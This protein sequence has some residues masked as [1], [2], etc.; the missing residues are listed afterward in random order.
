MAN[1]AMADL[2]VPY[3]LKA[4]NLGANHAALSVIRVI[5][6]EVASDP[7]GICIR[8]HAEFNGQG[9]IDIGSGRLQIAA[10][11]SEAAPPH[12]PQ[13][14]SPIFDLSETSLD[15]ELFV[16]RD[17]SLIVGQGESTISGAGFQ[18]TRD[19]LDVWDALPVDAPP[20]DFPSS[21]FTLDLILNL[22]SVRPP[23]LHPAKMTD[24]GLL[25]PDPAFKEVSLKLPRLRFR[26]SHGNQLNS[27]LGFELVSAGATGLDDPGDI[28]E[29]ELIAMEPPYAFVG[30]PT[31]RVVGFGFRKAVLDLSNDS[32]PPEVVAKFGFGDDWGGL[33]LPEARIFIAPNGAQD[34]AI[35]AGVRDLLIGFGGSA[36]ISGDFELAVIDQGHGALVLSARFFDADNKAYGIERLSDTTGRITVPAQ[37]RMVI[38]VQGG[39]PPYTTS[40]TI[41]AGAAQSG[42]V[43]NVD[44]S[45]TP[46]ATLVIG[47]RDTS[48]GTPKTATLTIQAQLGAPS[49]TLPA[50]GGGPAPA[51][52]ATADTAATDPMIVIAYQNDTSV[53][54]TTDPRNPA[55]MWSVITPPGGA[56]T[57]PTATFTV[58]V[59]PG[60]SR[61]VRARLPATT[62][63]SELTFYFYFDEPARVAN[64]QQETTILGNYAAGSDNIWSTRAASPTRADG[65][66]PGGQNAFDA[67]QQI[68]ETLV[69]AG[70]TIKVWG[71]ASF[72]GE[73][74]KLDYNYQL[75]RRRAIAVR[76][77]L[78]SRHAA[79]V[80]DFT[81]DPE[82]AN[83]TGYGGGSARFANLAAWRA[84]WQTHG[85]PNRRDWWRASVELPPGLGQP[86]K[87]G[88]RTLTRPA[89]QTPPPQIPV[90]DPPAPSEPA[91]PSW[92]R[93]AKLKVRIVRDVLVAVEVDMEVDF[94]TAAE[95]R[96]N[97]SGQVPGG[98]TPTQGRTMR[99]GAPLAPGNPADGITQLR[100][101]A[102][103]DQATGLVTAMIQIGADPADTDGLFAFGWL[104][105]ET[106]PANKDIWLT[107]AGS[108]ISF[109]PMLVD[110]STGNRGGATDAALTVAALAIPG[111]VAL[112]PWFRV[113]RVIV[114]G[115]EYLQRDHASGVFEAYL[116]FDV[117]ADGGAVV[118]IGGVNLNP[119]ARYFP[120]AVRYKAIGLRFGNGDDPA[121]PH[122]TLKP[123]FDASKGF[124]IDVARGGS[125]KIA[126]PF[127]KVLK[128]LAARLS[129]TNPLT[130]EVDIGCGIDLGVVTIERARLRVYLEE[131]IRPPELTAFAASIDVPGAIAGRGYMEMGPGD[132]PGTS[133]IAG[134]IDVTIRPISLRVAAAFEMQDVIDPNDASHR[135]TAIY[136]GL[137]LVLPVG[138]PLGTSGLGIFGFRGI[139]GMHYIRNPQRGANG[140]APALGWLEQ[141][142]GQPHLLQ[143]PVHHA[144]LWKPKIDN[145]AFGVGILLGTMEGGFIVNLDGTLLLELPGPRVAI[146]MNARIISPPPAL[147]GMGS[148]GGI[149]AIIEITPD[150]FLIGVIIDYDISGLIKIHIPV[151]AFFSFTDSSDWHFYLGQRTNPVAVSVLDIVKAT[152]YLM[153]KGNGLDALPA[154]GLPAITGFAI[155][156]GA[157]ASFTWGDTSVGL[158][159]RIAGGFDAVIGFDPFLL[160]GRFEL[161][162]ELRLFIV[163]IGAS[164]ELDIQVI[165]QTGGFKTHIH[166]EACG[167]I[168]FFFFSIEGCVSIT[169]G[170][171]NNKPDLPDLLQKLSVKSR[172][173]A[174]LVGTGVDRPIDTSLGEGVAQ[175]TAPADNDPRL[176]VVPIDSVLVLG[177]ALPPRAPGLQ[178]KGADITNSTGQAPGSFVQRGSEM[179]AYTLSAVDLVRHDGGPALLGGNAPATWW[180]PNDASGDNVNAQLALL[181]WEPD[182]ATKAI[183]KTEQRKE[184]IKQRWSRVCQDSAPPARVLWTFLD[185]RLG[186]SPHGWDLEG[187]PWPDPP[188]TR[189]KQPPATA[190][191]VTE[192]W[193]TGNAQ[194]DAKRG[195][196]PA[197]VV[198]GRIKCTD[199]VP[200]PRIAVGD[201]T[202][203]LGNVAGSPALARTMTPAAATPDAPQLARIAHLAA[204]APNARLIEKAARAEALPD[205]PVDP[206]TV[207]RKISLGGP[208]SRQEIG[209]AF[210]G[211]AAAA[212]AAAA[213]M[214]C[215]TRVLEAPIFDDGRLIVFGNPKDAEAVRAALKEAG[216]E[217]GPLNDV[218]VLHTGAFIDCNVLLFVR[219]TFFEGNRLVLRTLDATGHELSRVAVTVADRLASKPL[220]PRW[221][222]PAGPWARDVRDVLGWKQDARANGFEPAWVTAKGG[223][224]ADRIEI[225]VVDT[226]TNDAERAKIGVGM[227]VIPPYFLGAF[228]DASVA[229]IARADSE[230]TEIT[231]E[232]SV[233]TQILG[234]GP[235][236]DA[237]LVPDKLY[238]V[239]A[240]WTG[241]RQGDGATAGK[242]Q[243]FWF[244]TDANAPTRLDPWVLLTTP[245]DQEGCAFRLEPV[246]IVF[247][248]HNVDRLFD[249][250]GKELRIRFTASSAN[251]PAPTPAVPHPFPLKGGVIKPAGAMVLSPW[252]DAA[253]D[254]VR[255]LG[256]TCIPVDGS[257]DRQSI[258]TIPILLDPYTD[259]HMDVVMV[260]KGAPDNTE[261]TRVYRRNFSTGAYDTMRHFAADLQG[262]K[263]SHRALDPGKMAAL[264]AVFAGRRPQ[265][266]ELD[267]Q[268]RLAGLEATVGLPGARILVLWEQSGGTPPQ[269]VG[270]LLE[271]PEPLWR[272]RPHPEKQT[273]STGPSDAERWVLGTRE[274][275]QPQTG[276]TTNAPLAAGGFIRAPGDQ[277][278]LVVLGANARGKRFT[279]DLVRTASTDTYLPI[280]EER[281]AV[282]DLTLN[283]APWEE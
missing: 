168:D 114:F 152:G 221:T 278:A 118:S 21:G 143:S 80:F 106:K 91:P 208:I 22:P 74:S 75:A 15:F 128:I 185:E 44:L 266:S 92:F 107:L 42:R 69:P 85:D 37:T 203:V 83:S 218:V 247:N 249:A 64:P 77:G 234:P 135:A 241:N 271:A 200:P 225:G 189:R 204:V 140:A 51:L 108:Y 205:T 116:L 81:I 26:L 147:D 276:A 16:P 45:A 73:V 245:A 11:T 90:N 207:A 110:F 121:T 167:H 227:G 263:V 174:L 238:Q 281:H 86:E 120:P 195:I 39:L 275:L 242:T 212:P 112:I 27:Q 88:D 124:T 233:L 78:S 180:T 206:L 129:R 101:L 209:A 175:D 9:L 38:D 68:F 184:Q 280:A 61:T 4:D 199:T 173:P 36:G 66:A 231:K 141:S 52:P 213:Q 237:Y 63:N 232:R 224:N 24:R 82:P 260:D 215:Q 155:G 113:E 134:Q 153:I 170:N 186:P 48:A 46:Q 132:S 216:I 166:G 259:Y 190:M 100:F 102:Q 97:A 181:T 30:G 179:Y 23:F 265:G 235:T 58:D 98:A 178:F 282:V 122:F 163:S 139:F 156:A 53:T 136:V 246:Q 187:I 182:P 28:G 172:S 191:L 119:I 56:E 146:V 131:P 239:T 133:K 89:A 217:H 14:R 79:R 67:S 270:V 253:E 223:K 230:Q 29:A 18:P 126:P 159:L 228:D 257:R 250:Y 251:H 222:D 1:V 243:S 183:E 240:T 34:L 157:A 94:Q 177:M 105:G 109:W 211:P 99:N 148:S 7:F 125:I 13:R 262:L 50:P 236:D 176:P 162:G 264:N 194:I 57:G 192:A 47:A 210:L 171:D 93:S 255:E 138:I 269:P 137:N 55:L 252:E 70:S 149:L 214:N 5:D 104:P 87:H 267:D 219:R 111:A 6:F 127:D 8:G 273:D 71:E 12:D 95:E 164:A 244:R 274:W 54:L 76:E 145:W 165:G 35:E 25:I 261:G 198:G 3:L 2:V 32:T 72:E 142:D 197:F 117:E 154:K 258:V 40:L 96:I 201:L 20:S 31:D 115:G 254:A 272:S 60:Q 268:L 188:E 33:Y 248:T 161:S 49:Q 169:I 277:R 202:H 229:E 151:E 193:R 150:H 226:A 158:Y 144:I 41:G 283:A 59:P 103:S 10:A 43:F 196:I 65:R 130:F 19:V 220:P 17:G 62:V 123:V 84:N 279:L 256:L 160:A